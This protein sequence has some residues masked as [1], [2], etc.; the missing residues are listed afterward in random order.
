MLRGHLLMQ[1][2]PF[3]TVSEQI[4][5][6]ESRG[7]TINNL[8]CARMFLITHNYCSIINDYGRFFTKSAHVYITGT[9]LKDINFVYVFDKGIK[10]ILFTHTLEFEKH[11]KSTVAY[12]FCK[13][14]SNCTD[15]LYFKSY[16]HKNKKEIDYS[17][18]LINNIR[19]VIQY[20]SSPK[21]S[22]NEIKLYHEKYNEIP[23]WIVIQFM[24]L[25][26]VIK[27][28]HCS[29][30]AI[31]NDISKTFSNFIQN[32]QNDKFITV[33]PGDFYK[34]MLSIK[35]IRNCIAHNNR[36]FNISAS[37]SLPYMPKIHEPQGIMRNETKSDL[38]NILL[39]FQ[40]LISPEEY[41]NMI[42]AFKNQIEDLK[43]CTGIID[44]N[45]ITE[46]LGFPKDWIDRL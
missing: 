46:S 29:D 26:D 38:Y 23:L 3:K 8:D 45:T 1:N 10:T 33:N 20:Y 39:I 4:E 27:L 24:Y 25:G 15:Y 21:V 31:Q 6:L 37:R 43:K 11:L 40:C 12:Y 16:K 32:Y 14:H 22:P 30:D 35:D 36:I 44:Y 18:A 28:Y 17:L 9:T 13:T 7:I 5:I 34:I 42:L 19:E 41:E 2:K